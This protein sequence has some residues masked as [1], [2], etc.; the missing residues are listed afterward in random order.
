[1]TGDETKAGQGGDSPSKAAVEDA[2]AIDG[3]M[4]RRNCRTICSG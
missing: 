4:D 3:G 2:I 1:M